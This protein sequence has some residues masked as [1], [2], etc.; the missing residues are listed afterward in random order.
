MIFWDSR[1]LKLLAKEEDQYTVSYRFKF[2][3]DVCAWTFT[4]V[5]GPNAYGN[6]DYLWDEL[7]DIRG[8][9]SDLWFIGRDFNITRFP[10]ERNR[11]GRITGFMRRFS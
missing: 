9:W 6:R 5:Y 7:G 1:V 3:V 2:L 11:E 4:R 8:L 10:N